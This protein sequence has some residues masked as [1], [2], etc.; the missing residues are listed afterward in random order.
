ML[1]KARIDLKKPNITAMKKEGFTL[2]DM[3]FHTRY[4]DGLNKL[5][6]VIGR[7]KKLGI[8]IAITDHNTIK[9]S[10]EASKLKEVM[11][12][13][14]IE[15]TTKEGIHILLYFYTISDLISFYEK[16]I[17]KNK[18]KNPLFCLKI[19]V[20]EII[21]YAK[22][23]NSIICAAHP[24]AIFWTGLCKAYHKPIVNENTYKK[25]DAIEVIT[26]SNMKSRNRLAIEFAAKN[27]KSIT[28]GTDG[29]TLNEMGGVLTYTKQPNT[30]EE[31]LD[32]I[33][34]KTNFVIGKETFIVRKAASHSIKIKS[35]GKT[36]ISYIKKAVH[37]M[38]L[39][40]KNKLNELM[41]NG[42]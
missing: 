16:H 5:E 32:A 31:F 12:I 28:G 17:L 29:H 20:N 36:P 39:R 6:K 14:G 21:D 40:Q 7:A 15:A 22:E 8:G 34:N 35:A 26:G 42:F 4:S 25:V 38:K 41:E 10:V 11:S 27:N 23:F 24:F 9:G 37:Y 1:V 30:R 13:P 18:N 19:G 3:H 2:I 33:K